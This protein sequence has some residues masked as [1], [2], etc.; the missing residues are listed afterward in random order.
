[1]ATDKP[2]AALA[3]QRSVYKGLGSWGQQLHV[4]PLGEHC[5]SGKGAGVQTEGWSPKSRSV[6]LMD[7][8][9]RLL[10]GCRQG[11]SKSENSSTGQKCNAR[12][13][14]EEGN[15]NVRSEGGTELKFVWAPENER[16]RC[17]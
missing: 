16:R 4:V 2:A 5:G 6:P 12:G 14:W 17:P 9:D 8:A 7:A 11:Q 13:P 3:A 1:M 10:G 15:S